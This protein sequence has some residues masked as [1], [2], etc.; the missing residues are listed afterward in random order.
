MIDCMGLLS[1]I[2]RRR[3]MKAM[4]NN[5]TYYWISIT[6]STDNLNVIATPIRACN[7]DTISLNSG[8]PVELVIGANNDRKSLCTSGVFRGGGDG[9][10]RDTGIHLYV[11]IGIH[12]KT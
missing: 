6:D 1:G 8:T 3:I 10:V 7:T 5:W 11:E 4:T 12:Q 9:W 2:K